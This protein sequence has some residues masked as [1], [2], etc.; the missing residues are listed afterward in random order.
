MAHGLGHFL[1]PYPCLTIRLN[2]R[3]AGRAQ[4]Q[5]WTTELQ[6]SARELDP[7]TTDELSDPSW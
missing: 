4:G 2:L 1:G 6:R 7:A 5:L 3:R